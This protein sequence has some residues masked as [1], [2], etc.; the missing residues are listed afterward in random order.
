M[1][2]VTAAK[3]SEMRNGEARKVDVDG[4]AVVI[5]RIGDD[6]Y[7]LA[8][9]CSHAEA[10]LSEGD[11]YGDDLEIECPL[12]GST[13]DLESGEACNLPATEPVAVYTATVEGDDV[14]VE[15]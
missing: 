2:R 1:S 13:F 10:S 9:T 7:A 15:I 3:F 6:V 8:D 5:V 4:E 12:H 11:V 14:V